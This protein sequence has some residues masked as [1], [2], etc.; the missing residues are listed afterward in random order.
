VGGLESHYEKECGGAE[1][2]GY[3]LVDVHNNQKGS[4]KDGQYDTLAVEGKDLFT[5]IDLDMQRLG[6]QLMVNKKG[7]IVALDPRP[8]RCSA[9]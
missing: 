5:G 8:V 9:W 7:S 1:G 3:V 4:F 6:E 2:V